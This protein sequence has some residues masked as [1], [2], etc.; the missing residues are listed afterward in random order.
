MSAFFLFSDLDFYPTPR[1]TEIQCRGFDPDGYQYGS[2]AHDRSEAAGLA[3]DSA[4]VIAFQKSLPAH[5]RLV[6][7]TKL[8]DG[9]RINLI[10]DMAKAGLDSMDVDVPAGAAEALTDMKAIVDGL[11][12]L[13]ALCE[14]SKVAQLRRELGFPAAGSP[15]GAVMSPSSSYVR[16]VH[17]D[18]SRRVASG[19][20]ATLTDITRRP[21]GSIAP[22]APDCP[23]ARVTIRDLKAGTPS[24]LGEPKHSDVRPA[25]PLPPKPDVNE[26]LVLRPRLI[27]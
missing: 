7:L 27:W 24:T 25:H 12:Y 26:P 21:V 3:W 15:T 17:A 10:D 19:M 18:A 9:A 23:P 6:P 16:A 2:R 11:Q 13:P 22:G 14:P 5:Q 4:E 1:P 20:F 8:S